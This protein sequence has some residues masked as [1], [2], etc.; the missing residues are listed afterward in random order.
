M[1]KISG[2]NLGSSYPEALR[3]FP[4]SLQADAGTISPLHHDRLL[5]NPSQFNHAIR[6]YVVSI[7][8]EE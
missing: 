3:G 7:L 8:K 5:P 1:W 6:R 2:S 4:Q